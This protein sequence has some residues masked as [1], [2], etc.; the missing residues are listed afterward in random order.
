MSDVETPV[1]ADEQR[2]RRV[3]GDTLVR[4]REDA[5]ALLLVEDREALVAVA[6]EA[7]RGRDVEPA[8]DG[9]VKLKDRLLSARRRTSG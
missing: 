2:A 3:R 5:E 1:G 7:R 9:L 8:V 6:R 4:N